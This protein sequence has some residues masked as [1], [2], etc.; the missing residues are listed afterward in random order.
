MTP[1]RRPSSAAISS[2]RVVSAATF[3]EYPEVQESSHYRA[4]TNHRDQSHGP[5]N[6][7]HYHK[8]R[9]EPTRPEKGTE[10]CK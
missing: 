8:R 2:R 3:Y 5:T 6:Q 1:E 4:T 10:G 7:T 9:H